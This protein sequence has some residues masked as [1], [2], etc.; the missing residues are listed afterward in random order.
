MVNEQMAL[1][2]NSS[3]IHRKKITASFVPPIIR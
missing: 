3:S 1:V 2:P